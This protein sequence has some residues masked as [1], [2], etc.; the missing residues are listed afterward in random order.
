[1]IADSS[2]IYEIIEFKHYWNLSYGENFVNTETK[3]I[4]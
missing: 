4:P 2:V 1:M 3:Q